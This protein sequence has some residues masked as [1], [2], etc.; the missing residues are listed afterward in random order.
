MPASAPVT[1]WSVTPE[2]AAATF[3]E[4]VGAQVR[5]AVAE[6]SEHIEDPTEWEVAAS[7]ILPLEL[8]GLPDEVL[9]TAVEL[10]RDAP[11][12]RSAL[13]G[14]AAGAS[15][16]LASRALAHLVELD[17]GWGVPTLEVE[18]AWQIANGEPV[19]A[20]TLVCRREGVE[21]LQLF[22]FLL[23]HDESAGAIKG[24]MAVPAPSSALAIEGLRAEALRNGLEP[25][26]LDPAA[27]FAEVVEAARR[28]ALRGFRPD[29][30]GLDALAILLRAGGIEDAESLLA[31]LEAAEP[32]EP[33]DSDDLPGDDPVEREID[34]ICDIAYGWFC[35]KEL[36][37]AALDAAIEVGGLWAEYRMRSLEATVS[38]CKRDELDQFVLRWVPA[39]VQLPQDRVDAFPA[40]LAAVLEFLAG[41]FGL[42]PR[43]ARSLGKRA[44]SHTAAFRKLMETRGGVMD[45]PAATLAAQLRAAGVDIRNP[46]EVARWIEAFNGRSF[47][48]R[49][50][51]LAPSLDRIVGRQPPSSRGSDPSG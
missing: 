23:E 18:S 19:T 16:V 36:D 38:E 37:D 14:M 3:V 12:G 21:Q 22:S 39:R 6:M 9:D 24:G 1:V 13:R 35:A 45:G 51:L 7:S 31:E 11:G 15:P 4:M 10:V 5:A 34:R 27:A 25:T 42:D 47:D 50:R 17:P 41:T 48:E 43:T 8:A 49:D 29:E 46:D 26:D 40:N 20:I 33:T 44:L 32:F 28:G 2:Q 30:D